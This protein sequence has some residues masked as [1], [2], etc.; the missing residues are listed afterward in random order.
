MYLLLYYI[1]SVRIARDL[2]VQKYIDTIQ[3]IYN[4]AAPATSHYAIVCKTQQYMYL[5]FFVLLI[6]IS[7]TCIVLDQWIQQ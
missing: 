2:R 1:S 4:T 7:S 3:Y 6:Y 5:L